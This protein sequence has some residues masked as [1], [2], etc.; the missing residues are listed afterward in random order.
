MFDLATKGGETTQ[1]STSSTREQQTISDPDKDFIVSDDKGGEHLQQKG[2][3]KTTSRKR[4]SPDL[5]DSDE[6]IAPTTNKKA[7]RKIRDLESESDEED[8]TVRPEK[9]VASKPEKAVAR[10]DSSGSDD[11]DIKPAKQVGKAC[12]RKCN[13]FVIDLFHGF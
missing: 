10:V 2:K 11:E 12:S 13:K 6:D 4:T 1:K 9:Q 7:K 5:D 8:I 3:R